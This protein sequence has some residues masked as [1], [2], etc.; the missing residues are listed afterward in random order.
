MLRLLFQVVESTTLF[1]SIS[2]GDTHGLIVVV[3]TCNQS[4]KRNLRQGVRTLRIWDNR[5]VAV[6]SWLKWL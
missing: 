5:G 2:P 1:P 3:A 6:M 4:E